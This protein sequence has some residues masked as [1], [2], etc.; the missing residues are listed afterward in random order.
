M[1][2][3]TESLEAGA[4]AID[5]VPE[6]GAQMPAS[7]E[8]QTAR[9]EMPQGA[10]GRS[11]RPP[12][13]QGAPPAVEEEDEVEEI[14]REGSRSQTVRIFHKRG[15]EVVVVQEEDTTREVRRL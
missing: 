9:P 12:S 5:V 4:G 7:S 13:P 8:E 10:V 2:R 1:A 3:A 15:D 11:V 14:E 6:S